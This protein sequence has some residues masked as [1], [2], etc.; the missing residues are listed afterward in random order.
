MSKLFNVT[1]INV[2]QFIDKIDIAYKKYAIDNQSYN[3]ITKS[4][5]LIDTFYSMKKLKVQC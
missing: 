1:D 5:E 3:K 2:F 4:R